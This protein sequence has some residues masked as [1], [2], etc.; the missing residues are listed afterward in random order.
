MK[1]SRKKNSATELPNERRLRN[2]FVD[3]RSKIEVE[4]RARTNYQRLLRH[5]TL[6]QEPRPH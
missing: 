3:W 5:R 4:L 1:S 2:W 6:R